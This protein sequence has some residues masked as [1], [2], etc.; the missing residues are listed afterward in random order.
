MHRSPT[1]VLQ[2]AGM[3]IFS[4]ILYQLRNLHPHYPVFQW[5]IPPKSAPTAPQLHMQPMQPITRTALHCTL[6]LR[7]SAV[8]Q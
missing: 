4:T 1:A 3:P 6:P 5:T 2:Q 8:Q 7:G